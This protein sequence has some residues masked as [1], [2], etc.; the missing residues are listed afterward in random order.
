MHMKSLSLSAY[1]ITTTDMLVCQGSRSAGLNYNV[2]SETECLGRSLILITLMTVQIQLGQGPPP[3]LV[4][5]ANQTTNHCG[6]CV[7]PITGSFSVIHHYMAPQASRGIKHSY[8]LR[9]CVIRLCYNNPK[10]PAV[11][12]NSLELLCLAPCIHVHIHTAGRQLSM[13]PQYLRISN[14]ATSESLCYRVCVCV[15]VQRSQ[16]ELQ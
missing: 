1:C 12:G 6:T 13:S 15:L 11:V 4:G 5:Q 10:V 16:R 3:S 2:H 9:L 8:K 7:H 14:S